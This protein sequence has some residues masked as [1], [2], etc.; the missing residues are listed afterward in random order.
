MGTLLQDVRFALRLLTRRPGFTIIAVL[1]LA[2]GIGANTAIFSVIDAVLLRPLPYAD[3]DRLVNMYETAPQMERGSVSAPDY[4]DWQVQS[5]TFSRLAAYVSADMNLQNTAAPERLAALK[6]S[7]NLFSLL[8]VKPLLGRAFTAGEDGPNASHV[9]V[10]S[11]GLWRRYFG[12]DPKL[13]GRTLTLDSDSYTVIGVMPQQFR[14]PAS[15]ATDVWIPLQ[16]RP[17]LVAQR[18]SRS[19]HVIGRLKSGED[20]NTAITE[21]HQIASRLARQ[22][23]KEQS[24]WT[25]TLR[26]LRQDITGKVRPALLVLLGAAGLVL[27]IA[28]SNVANLSLSRAT[29]RHREVA[30]R[31]AVGAQRHRLIRQLLTESV[32]LALLGAGVGLVFAWAATHT[33]VSLG[34]SSIPF[35]GSVGFNPRVFAFLLLVGV[36][37][38]IIFGLAPA[39]HA[40]RVDL[41]SD[42]KEGAPSGSATSGSRRFRNVLVVAEIALALVLLVGAGLLMRAFVRLQNTET[43]IETHNLLTLHIPVPSQQYDTSVSTRFFQPMLER[44]AAIPGVRVA[45]LTSA[46]PLQES[47][48]FGPLRIEGRPPD[49]AGEQPIAEQRT[50]SPGYFRALGIPVIKGRDFTDH[51]AEASRGGG[52]RRAGAAPAV[53]LINQEL[54]RRYFPGIDPIGQRIKLGDSLSAPI[55]GVVG[56]VRESALDTPPSSTMYFSYLQY[57]MSEMTLVISTSV[58]PMSI[59]S[60]VRTA[61]HAVDPN[62][63]LYDVETMDQVVSHSIA[64][65]QFYLSLLGTFAVVAFVLAIVGIYG[66]MSYAVTQRTREIGIRMALGARTSSV[67]RLVMRDGMLLVIAGIACGTIMALVLSHLLSHLLY[68]VS[69]TDPITFI[70]VAIL[71]GVVALIASYVPARRAAAVDPTISLRYEA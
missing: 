29:D 64:D 56:N 21:M 49:K 16:M 27:L 32:L 33:L 43:G 38:G 12:A 30:I 24:G 23:P 3:A 25:V 37:T 20:L 63:P 44:V 31:L 61:I 19:L 58:P 18:G 40:T 62:Q 50:V 59:T 4:L 36:A 14:F 54:A 47:Y 17:T 45:G 6:T 35:A 9:I 67:Q 69:S 55:V 46:L 39:L 71:L 42:L 34:A 1:S 5:Q 26:P 11:E 53:V 52:T 70:C 2:L 51:D 66:V 7:S 22:Y 8:G 48:N 57:P 68:G 41:H 13:V 60:G 10:V 28:C 15:A 65:R